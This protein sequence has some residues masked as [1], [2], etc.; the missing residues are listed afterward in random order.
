MATEKGR[1]IMVQAAQP[2]S[3]K[4]KALALQKVVILPPEPLYIQNRFN[5]T[6][7]VN[8]ITVAKSI[9]CRPALDLGQREMEAAF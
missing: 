3:V 4:M 7:V 5:P 8:P 6:A 9:L 2:K 1:L